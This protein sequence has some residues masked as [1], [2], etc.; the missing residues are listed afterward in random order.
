MDEVFSQFLS[1]GTFLLAFAVVITTFFARRIVETAVPSIKK[2]ADANAPGITYPTALSRWWNEVILYFIPVLFGS[3]LALL[4]IPLIEIEGL[5]T[6]G[7]RLIFGGVVGWL[8]GFLF[9]IAKK[10]IAQKTG[11]ELPGDS[12]APPS[13]GS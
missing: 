11:V 5:T 9:K 13:I 10:I 3:M 8:S 7:G 6:L 4:K 12:M 1:L 2:R